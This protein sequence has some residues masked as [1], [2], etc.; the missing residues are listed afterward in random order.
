MLTLALFLMAFPAV[1][2]AKTPPQAQVVKVN[3]GASA[4]DRRMLLEKLNERGLDRG[5]EVCTRR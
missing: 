3:I 5:F 4:F 2:Q 1:T